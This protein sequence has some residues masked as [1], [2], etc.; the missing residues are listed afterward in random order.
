MYQHS[1]QTAESHTV[2]SLGSTRASRPHA[3]VTAKQRATLRNTTPR[4][5]DQ[6]DGTFDQMSA[7]I[8][9]QWIHL[10]RLRKA[11]I[12]M[13][14]VSSHKLHRCYATQCS[15]KKLRVNGLRLNGRHSS[16]VTDYNVSQIDVITEALALRV[17]SFVK[18][19]T[20]T[21]VPRSFFVPNNVQLQT[22]QTKW[23]AGIHYIHVREL[24]RGQWSR[25]VT[26]HTQSTYIILHSQW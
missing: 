8:P 5:R 24:Q 26:A 19:V 6:Q 18:W 12:W 11:T 3:R 22:A 14:P 17:Q 21:S 23:P 10:K 16:T 1:Q 15:M 9:P 2:E 13:S 25:A 4:S 20:V 7:N